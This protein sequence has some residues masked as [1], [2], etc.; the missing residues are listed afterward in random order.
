MLTDEEIKKILE[1]HI[2]DFLSI[3]SSLPRG[4]TTN[5]LGQSK[6]ELTQALAAVSSYKNRV[7][8]L[9]NSPKL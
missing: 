3:L 7:R 8:G 2:E 5:V 6:T 9:K 4:R 1:L